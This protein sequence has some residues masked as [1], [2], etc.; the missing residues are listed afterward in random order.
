MGRSRWDMM[1]EDFHHKKTP[2]SKIHGVLYN[3][4]QKVGF[5]QNLYKA[6]QGNCA[7]SFY[8]GGR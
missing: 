3:R 1:V 2:W 8:P 7:I 5:I 6:I 4:P